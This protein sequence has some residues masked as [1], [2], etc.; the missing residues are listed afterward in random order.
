MSFSDFGLDER[1]LQTIEEL[2]YAA[3]MPIQ[4][5]AIP[6]VLAGRDILGRSQTGTGK[7]AAFGIPMLQRMLPDSGRRIRAL[8]VEPTRELANQVNDY[9]MD[10]SR[11]IPLHGFSVTGGDD[12]AT[13][14]HKIRLGADWV[15]A[16]PGRLNA[17]LRGGYM[18][19]GG[20]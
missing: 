14:E 12:Y 9:L 18:D 11:Y 17:H 2:R 3:P 6:A 16:T 10:L 20:S 7:T 1:L 15:V 13:Q 5:Q 4:A 19:L 8:I